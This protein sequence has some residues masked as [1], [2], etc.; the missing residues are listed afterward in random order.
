MAGQI[1][2]P[3]KHAI[4]LDLFRYAGFGI[5]GQVLA[6]FTSVA[7][8][9]LRT[10]VEAA[11]VDEW[12]DKLSEFP[13]VPVDAELV[14]AGLFLSRRYHI[15]YYDAAIIA[16]AERLGASVLYTED[17]NHGQNYGAVRV[18]NPFHPS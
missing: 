3:R 18:I 10:T 16:A 13:V 2:E 14:R 11:T 15:T 12:L 1:D 4:A 5:S 9:R 6:E 7:T 8:R 17:L